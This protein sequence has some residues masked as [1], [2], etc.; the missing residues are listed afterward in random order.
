MTAARADGVRSP[1]GVRNDGDEVLDKRPRKAHTSRDLIFANI[2]SEVLFKE[3][4]AKQNRTS[5]LPSPGTCGACPLKGCAIRA[6]R[7][8][9]GEATQA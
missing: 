3:C 6:A 1:A 9:G 2:A 7:R 4:G 8:A 5:D